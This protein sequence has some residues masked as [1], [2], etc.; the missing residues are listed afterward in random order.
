MFGAKFCDDEIF[1][2]DEPGLFYK[3]A[4]GRALKVKCKN[5]SVYLVRFSVT[6]TDAS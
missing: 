2:A 1:N 5:L 4:L 6:L 3:L